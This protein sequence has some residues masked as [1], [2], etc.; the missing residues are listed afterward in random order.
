MQLEE[1]MNKINNCLLHAFLGQVQFYTLPIKLLGKDAE[2]IPQADSWA[3]KDIMWNVQRRREPTEQL[4]SDYVGHLLGY[5]SSAEA[6]S[7]GV[8]IVCLRVLQ[9]WPWHSNVWL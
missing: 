1:T 9:H 7:N 4:L 5:M 3:L 8:Y 6:A 2:T